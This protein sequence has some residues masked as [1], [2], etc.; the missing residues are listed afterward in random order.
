M[1]GDFLNDLLT[2]NYNVPESIIDRARWMNCDISSPHR[3]LVFEINDFNI[4]TNRYRNDE[5]KIL[6]LKTDIL[7]TIN[8]AAKTLGLNHISAG[9]SDSIIVLIDSSACRDEET[10]FRWALNIKD[11]LNQ[12]YPKLTISVG[13]GKECLQLDDY[14]VSYNEALKCLNIINMYHQKGQITSLAKLGAHAVIFNAA[15]KP[16]LISFSSRML[17]SLIEYDRIHESQLI[18]TLRTFLNNNGN[19]EKTARA[20]AMSITGLKYRLERIEKING[21]DLNN[22]QVRFNLQLALN[23]LDISGDELIN[24]Y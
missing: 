15:N 6:K 21:I 24:I 4:F 12:S 13:V 19:L 18:I 2:G 22:A 10:V 16:E 1:R 9:K 14:R 23:I 7:N 20:L 17:G 5:K 3:V 8:Q 11:K